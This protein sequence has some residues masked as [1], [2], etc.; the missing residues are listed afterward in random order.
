MTSVPE[1]VAEGWRKTADALSITLP[2]MIDDLIG[3]CPNPDH[4]TS[5]QSARSIAAAA[6]VRDYLPS[7]IYLVRDV[8]LPIGW[9][10][11]AARRAGKFC[12]GLY[13]QSY[14]SLG[15]WAKWRDG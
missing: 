13:Y 2:A 7:H 11:P 6:T 1:N 3:I 4:V 12:I 14:D 8:I 9:E 10:W 15:G 5:L